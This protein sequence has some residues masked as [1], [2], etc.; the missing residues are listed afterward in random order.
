[1]DAGLPIVATE[2]GGVG[3]MV[4]HGEHGLLVAAGDVDAMARSVVTLLDEC[5]MR[6]A[7]TA[8]A[9]ESLAAYS[10]ERYY[11]GVRSLFEE[12]VNRSNRLMGV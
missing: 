2:V 12:V 9:S 11:A 1:M 8:A 7:L 6:L 10:P 3:E 5:R 4:R